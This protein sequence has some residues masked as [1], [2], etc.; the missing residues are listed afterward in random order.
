[1]KRACVLAALLVAAF[2][3]SKPS[4]PVLQHIQGRWRVDIH[5]SRKHFRDGDTMSSVSDDTLEEFGMLISPEAIQ[6][7]D[8]LAQNDYPPMSYSVVSQ[9]T[10]RVDIVVDA[11]GEPLVLSIERL[12][13][14]RIH[15][16]C[17]GSLFFGSP[18]WTRESVELITRP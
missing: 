18:I 15:V 2:G 5:E 6:T 1:M 16:T 12:G 17:E 10:D 8:R 14:D 3:C 11:R 4:P 7:L 13:D 9:S